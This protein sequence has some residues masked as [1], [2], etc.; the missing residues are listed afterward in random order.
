M[1]IISMFGGTYSTMPAYEANMFGTKYLTVIHSRML[2]A[3][4]VAGTCGPLLISK[5][6]AVSELKAI[7]DLAAKC[8]PIKFRETFGASID[9]LQ[10]L[11]DAKT[12]TIQKLMDIVPAGTVDP[13]P[14]LYDSTMYTMSGLA[15]VAALANFAV[16]PVPKKLHMVG[17]KRPHEAL[18]GKVETK[19]QT[20]RSRKDR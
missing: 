4:G 6:R 5:L 20:Q 11:A 12:V 19:Y 17:D 8:D 7:C 10:S 9:Q 16:R 13:T 14:Y 3:S 15:C 18:N 1:L 2:T